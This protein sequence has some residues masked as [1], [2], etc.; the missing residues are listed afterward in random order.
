M[1]LQKFTTPA[2]LSLELEQLTDAARRFAGASR[3]PQT[4]RAYQSAWNQFEKWAA[5]N[6]VQGLPV[7]PEVLALYLTHRAE[8]GASVSSMQVAIAAVV[9]VHRSAGLEG[10]SPR[11]SPALAEVW[12]GIRRTVGTAPRRKKALSVAEL[13][14]MMAACTEDTIGIRDRA[15]L[16]LGF[17]GALRRSELVALNTEDIEFTPEGMTVTVR[18]SKTDQSAAG[19]VVGIRY[20][21]SAVCPVTAVRVWLGRSGIGGT[22]AGSAVEAPAHSAAARPGKPIRE[23]AGGGGHRPVAPVLRPVT[24]HGVIGAGRLSPRDVG[25]RVKVIAGRIGLNSADIGGHSLRAG[26]ATSAAKAGARTA[27]IMR[28]G[29]W[30]SSKMVDEVYIRPATVFDGAASG[31]L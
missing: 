8:I 17:A 13:S 9:A 21:T 4:I 1:T 22:P 31:I 30:R 16:A 19:A 28:Q 18:R 29:R 7:S 26:L 11:T 5:S 25:R 12:Q 15:L 23:P 6:G 27:D 2:E 10:P 14:Q 24:R 20:G 3:S